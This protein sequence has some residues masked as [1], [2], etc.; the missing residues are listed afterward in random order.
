MRNAFIRALT[1]VAEQDERI[2]FL[3]AD[4]GYKLFDDFARRCPGRFLNVGVAEANSALSTNA[5]E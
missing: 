2:V 3:T 4:L 1:G 5:R